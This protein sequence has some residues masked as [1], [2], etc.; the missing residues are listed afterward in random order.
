MDTTHIDT[1]DQLGP[2]QLAGDYHDDDAAI[3]DSQVESHAAPPTP[4]Q[5]P[6][7]PHPTPLAGPAPIT[8]LLTGSL[9]FDKTWN[10]PQLLLPADPNRSSLQLWAASD[11]ATD[12]ARLGDD[13][14]KVQN[15]GSSALLYSGQL[16][17]FPLTLPGAHTGPVWAWC[18]DATGPVTVSF[19]AVTR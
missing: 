10:A 4:A 11:T 13:A 12:Y 6:Q 15:K 8:R 1:S 16:L 19:I 17:T 3:L 18:P 9:A 2:P 7:I 14:G 5:L